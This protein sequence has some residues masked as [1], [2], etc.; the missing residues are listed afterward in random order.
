M[1]Q[2]PAG[3]H[4]SGQLRRKHRDVITEGAGGVD[5]ALQGELHKG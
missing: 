2:E 5:V 1:D 4:W 3:W